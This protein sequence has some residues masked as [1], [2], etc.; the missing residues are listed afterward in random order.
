MATPHNRVAV[1]IKWSATRTPCGATT[2]TGHPCGREA[3]HA[4][5]R[6]VCRRVAERAL[7]TM[8]KFVSAVAS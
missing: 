5:G 8:G 3:G 4:P 6:H 7:E 2:E 1:D